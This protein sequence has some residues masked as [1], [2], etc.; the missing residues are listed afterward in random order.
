MA[1]LFLHIGLHKTGTTSIQEA[2]SGLDTPNI[3]YASLRFENHSIPIYTIFSSKRTQYGVWRRKGIDHG[4]I[5]ELRENFI[6]GLREA[7]KELKTRD[8]LISGEDISMLSESEVSNLRQTILEHTS[9]I[10]VIVYVRDPI[11][12]IKSNLQER[13][14]NGVNVIVPERPNYRAK[15]GKFMRQFGS[16]N[17][18]IREYNRDVFPDGDIVSDLAEVVGANAPSSSIRRN[19]SLSTE[20]V[21][22][23]YVLNK[24]SFNH[25]SPATLQHARSLCVKHLKSKLK[26]SFELPVQL[27]ASLIDPDDILWLH[28]VSGIDFRN[29]IVAGRHDFKSEDLAQYLQ[30]VDRDTLNALKRRRFSQVSSWGYGSLDADSSIILQEYFNAF[31]RPRLFTRLISLCWNRNP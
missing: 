23:L 28:D 2:F 29:R 21:R 12:S 14:K 9:D 11:E 20:A 7:L 8:V 17:L 18:I 22:V 25:E 31:L 16:A 15:I 3:K 10:K 27:I 30:E 26:G 4:Q 1:R 6:I 5:Q 19:G 13:I 24:M